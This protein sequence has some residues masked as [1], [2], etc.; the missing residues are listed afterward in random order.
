MNGEILRRNVIIVNPMGFHLRPMAAFARLASKY[1][2]QVTLAKEDLKVNGKNT[3]QLMG[4][5]AEQGTELILEVS[6][7]DAQ[8][9]I[10]ALVEILAAPSMDD[11][12]DPPQNG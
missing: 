3:L 8:V 11:D 5:A 9:A 6:G 7:S 4:L 10:E 1:Q 2:S 12:D